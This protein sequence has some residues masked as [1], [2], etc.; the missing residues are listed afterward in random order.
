VAHNQA[1]VS[2][3]IKAETALLGKYSD[4]DSILIQDFTVTQLSSYSIQTDMHNKQ[5]NVIRIMPIIESWTYLQQN[6]QNI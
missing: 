1:A 6:R 3:G 2:I 4:T 5:V